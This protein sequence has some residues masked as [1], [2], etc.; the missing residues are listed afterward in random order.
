MRVRCVAARW[1]Q[2]M[3]ETV[4]GA[5]AYS[6]YGMFTDHY[7]RFPIRNRS[8]VCADFSATTFWA[9][10]CEECRLVLRRVVQSP[11]RRSRFFRPWRHVLLRLKNRFAQHFA[12]LPI[13]LSG[14]S[15]VRVKGYLCSCSVCRTR[16]CS[17]ACGV[18]SAFGLC[19][20]PAQATLRSSLAYRC[21][22]RRHVDQDGSTRI[23]L[24]ISGAI[25]HS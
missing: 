5:T 20:L 23:V 24:R 15:L 21:R 4:I 25:A 12:S 18:V 10:V 3:Q 16:R 9:V 17:A 1:P 22:A 7:Q 6:R 2:T 13:K 8:Y 14:R 19:P 11:A